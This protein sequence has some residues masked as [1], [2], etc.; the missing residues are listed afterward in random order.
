MPMRTVEDFTDVRGMFSTLMA[1]VALRYR[2]A[3]AHARSRQGRIVL[4]VFGYLALATALLVSAVGG[5]GAAG[6]AIRLG[7]SNLIAA[8]V[9]T[10]LFVNVAFASVFLGVSGHAALSDSTL[11]RYPLSRTSR[12][13]A[14]HVTA[15]LEPLWIISLALALGLAGGFAMMGEGKPW[16]GLPAA[17]LFVIATYLLACVIARVGEWVISMP[18]GPLVAIV[19]GVS[20]MMAAPL[21]PAWLARALARSGGLPQQTLL[22]WS[23]P[24]AAAQAMTSASVPA[25]LGAVAVLA[26]WSAALA[27]LHAAA[28]HLPR[29]TRTASAT[30]ARWD[31]PGDRIAALFGSGTAP[32]AGKMIRY[33]VRSPQTRYNY[34]LALPVLAVMMATN[35][36][37]ETGADAFLFALGAA[38]AL[39]ILATGTLSLN[40]F[41]FDGHGFRRYF[42][43]PVAPMDVI[44]TATIVSLIPGGALVFIGL[45]AWWMW[46]PGAVTATMMLMLVC[47]A[48]GGLLVFN[49]LGLWTSI[50]APRAIPFDMTFGNKLSPAANLVFI[51]A[52]VVFF[53][54]PLG[55]RS[56]G[57][58]VVLD[59]WW[60]APLL[61]VVAAGIQMTMVGRGA[62]MLTARREEMLAMIEG[63]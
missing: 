14:R 38:P 37:S 43:L 11:R 49:A 16:L 51:A 24:F 62:R 27:A 19:G 45:I 54:L 50:A 42:L 7:R 41:G 40:L 28:G 29:R 15:L 31:H 33:Y 56:L 10:G 60:M 39:G 53:G 59:A 6:A 36:R 61:L 21:A 44:R 26:A 22:E 9:L 13:I 23:P 57:I 58:G 20:L 35:G 17:F 4:L 12:V 2:L 30:L 46:S 52:M 34:P 32:L 55:L 63:R 25:A 1:L 48:F 3:W 18:G 47:A 5:L 8:V